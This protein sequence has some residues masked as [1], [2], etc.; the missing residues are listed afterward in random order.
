MKNLPAAP[1]TRVETWLTNLDGDH[2]AA[3][4]CALIVATF[5]LCM[6]PSIIARLGKAEGPARTRPVS[7]N[8][9]AGRTSAGGAR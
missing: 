4:V 7:S 9:K 2:L 5:L 1:P 3:I 8:R 6:V